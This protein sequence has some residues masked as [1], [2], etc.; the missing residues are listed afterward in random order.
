MHRDKILSDAMARDDRPEA[1]RFR[2]GSQQLTE[3]AFRLDPDD[4]A[5]LDWLGGRLAPKC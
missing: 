5:E 4:Q 3:M 2:D 1:E